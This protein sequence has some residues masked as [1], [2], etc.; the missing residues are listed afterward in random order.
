MSHYTK[1][2]HFCSN[3]QRKNLLFPRKS[4]YHEKKKF[5][6]LCCIILN[7]IFSCGGC[8]EVRA[9]S[10][11]TGGQ[12]SEAPEKG[13]TVTVRPSMMGRLWLYPPSMRRTPWYRGGSHPKMMGM[14]V[15]TIITCKSR[16][17]S[18][19]FKDSHQCSRSRSG[20]TGSTCFWASQIRIHESEV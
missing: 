17:S 9:R 5:A 16:S 2:E 14:K 18:S 19:F 4:Q 15:E 8:W 13:E 10:C 6:Y 1:F 7:K 20:S 11:H 3:S 12:M